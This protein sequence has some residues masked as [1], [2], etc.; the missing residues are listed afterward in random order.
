MKY[1]QER[2]KLPMLSKLLGIVPD[3]PNT[4]YGAFNNFALW[5]VRRCRCED[6][7]REG[8][9]IE[10]RLQRGKGA[11]TL[12]LRNIWVDWPCSFVK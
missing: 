5:G 2:E 12:P 10:S 3:G 7:G 6:L 8:Y 11:E 4:H 1:I 9:I